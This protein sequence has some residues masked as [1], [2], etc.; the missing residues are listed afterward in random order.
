MQALLLVLAVLCAFVA[1]LIG[2]GHVTSD[3]YGGWLAS[4]VG[5]VALAMLW[6][7]VPTGRV[8]I[9]RS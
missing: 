5:L 7:F 3:D 1:A 8:R 4:A 6:P 2:Y 9:D